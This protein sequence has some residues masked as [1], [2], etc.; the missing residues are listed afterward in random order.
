MD[1][2]ANCQGREREEKD[3]PDVKFRPSLKKDKTRLF[4]LR[5]Q[6]DFLFNFLFKERLSN[7]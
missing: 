1:A 7:S 2:N 6:G 3:A 4:I 5:S